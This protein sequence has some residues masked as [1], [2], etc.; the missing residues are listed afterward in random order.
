MVLI[1]HNYAKLVAS[2]SLIALICCLHHGI[3]VLNF[4]KPRT[5]AAKV[6]SKELYRSVIS[7]GHAL[8]TNA[9]IANSNE[10]W[11]DK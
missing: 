1:F 11:N 8:T 4:H 5:E 7:L 6:N 9:S 2:S 3:V 10:M